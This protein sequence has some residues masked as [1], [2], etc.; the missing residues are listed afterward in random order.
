MAIFKKN[1]TKT[2]EEALGVKVLSAVELDKFLEACANIYRGKPY[3]IGDK[4]KTVNFAN[5]IAGEIARLATMNTEVSVDGSARADWLQGVMD[6]CASEWRNWV[7]LG[8][9]LGTLILKPTED[10]LDILTPDRFFVLGAYN[11]DITDIVFRDCVFDP[12]REIY[13]TRLERHQ[14]DEVYTITNRVY[15][16]YAPY[17]LDHEVSIEVSPWNGINDEVVAEGVEHMLFGVFRFPGANNLDMSSPLGLPCFA[18]AVEELMDLEKQL[19]GSK[20]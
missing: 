8:C 16:G 17:D 4:V 18:K 6:D 7:E 19:K 1:K 9:A 5:T 15:V 3:W 13:Y 14:L 11:G 10:S 12:E 2:V 20:K